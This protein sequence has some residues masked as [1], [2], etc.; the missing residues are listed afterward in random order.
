MHSFYCNKNDTTVPLN[1]RGSSGLDTWDLVPGVI[2][3]T[4]EG[5]PRWPGIGA[6]KDYRYRW[7]DNVRGQRLNNEVT[8]SATSGL[9]YSPRLVRVVWE[10]KVKN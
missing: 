2:L 8:K 9:T 6:G 1:N 5:S 10:R 7:G 3:V 4:S